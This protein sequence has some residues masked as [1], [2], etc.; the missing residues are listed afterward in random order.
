MYEECSLQGGCC[1]DYR[2]VVDEVEQHYQSKRRSRY[3]NVAVCSHAINAVRNGIFAIFILLRLPHDPRWVAGSTIVCVLLALLQWVA[4]MAA[5]RLHPLGHFLLTTLDANAHYALIWLGPADYP[6]SGAAYYVTPWFQI[7]IYMQRFFIGPWF[8]PCIVNVLVNG[9]PELLWLSTMH[10]VPPGTVVPA[11]IV[12]AL[13]PIVPVAVSAAKERQLAVDEYV[14]SVSEKRAADE[15]DVMTELLGRTMPAFV[16]PELLGRFTSHSSHVSIAI[17]HTFRLLGVAFLKRVTTRREA[18]AVGLVAAQ[19]PSPDPKVDAQAALA[20]HGTGGESDADVTPDAVALLDR[21]AIYQRAVLT[22]IAEE[23]ARGTDVV[24]IKVIGDVTM[25]VAGLTSGRQTQL[26][27]NEGPSRRRRESLQ[28]LTSDNNHNSHHHNKEVVSDAVGPSAAAV[29]DVDENIPPTAVTA[30]VGLL[31]LCHTICSAAFED[32]SHTICGVH[33][34]SAAGGVLGE[35]G[36]IY[37]IFGDTVNTAARVMQ[38][39]PLSATGQSRLDVTVEALKELEAHCG[40]NVR[41]AREEAAATRNPLSSRRPGGDDITDPVMN[42]AT[43]AVSPNSALAPLVVG[44][45][46]MVALAQNDDNQFTFLNEPV[47]HDGHD[48]PGSGLQLRT[49][50]KV[51]TFPPEQRV[52]KGKGYLLIREVRRVEKATTTDNFGLSG[53]PTC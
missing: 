10:A 1:S 47:P 42:S 53:P 51:L 23:A 16:I 31:R 24:R 19:P 29:A 22:F 43:A 34:G 20:P 48:G 18:A 21:V 50:T 4:A 15:L 52:A 37:D 7:G 30:I 6:V 27:G 32:G 41:A 17:G 3:S 38:T 33:A 25:L 35:S 36:L 28:S 5:E 8:V 13:N 26:K 44:E 45:E 46:D 2:F 39:V 9:I 14:T 11:I 49:C 40:A 12:T